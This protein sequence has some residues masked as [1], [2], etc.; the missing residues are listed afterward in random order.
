MV[1]PQ[2]TLSWSMR[3]RLP[4][5]ARNLSVS[6]VTF[7]E[8]DDDVQSRSH[9]LAVEADHT[10]AQTSAIV[11]GFNNRV[12]GEFPSVVGVAGNVASDDRSFVGAGALNAASGSGVC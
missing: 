12:S 2:V 8:D 1:Q 6:Y 9:S 11:A 4:E 5:H 7:Y 10:F 3:Q